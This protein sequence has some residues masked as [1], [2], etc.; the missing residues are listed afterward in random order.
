MEENNRFLLGKY[1]AIQETVVNSPIEKRTV[2]SRYPAPTQEIVNI[3]TTY[4]FMLSGCYTSTS[5]SNFISRFDNIDEFNDFVTKETNKSPINLPML[6]KNEIF[7]LGFSLACN[8]LKDCGYTEY[9]KPDVHIKEVFSKTGICNNDEYEVFN[10]AREMAKVV[11]ITPYD[12]DKL[13]WIVCSGD[14]HLDKIKVGANKEVLINSILEI[15]N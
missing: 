5:A 6:L 1:A 11:G 7:G 2:I 15:I 9:L 14:F 12:L 8:F 4:K 13:L 10:S 3:N